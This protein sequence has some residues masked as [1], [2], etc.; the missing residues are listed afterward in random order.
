VERLGAGG[1]SF[2]NFQRVRIFLLSFP[3]STF[4]PSL[5]SHSIQSTK[6]NS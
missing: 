1:A 5:L 6:S 2:V 4:Y 3:D